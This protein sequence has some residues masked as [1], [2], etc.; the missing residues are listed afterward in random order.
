MRQTILKAGTMMLCLISAM[1]ISSC[2]GGSKTSQAEEAEAQPQQQ[3][4]QTLPDNMAKYTSNGFE[5]YWIC[6]NAGESKSDVSRYVGV[7]PEIIKELNISEGVPST[8]STFLIKADGK[9]LLFDAGMGSDKNLLLPSLKALGV[10][11]ENIDAIFI[12]HL[13]GD[14]T[15]GLAKDGKAVFPNATVYLSKQEYEGMDGAKVLE[16]YNGKI[17]QFDFN[18]ELI[19]GIKAIDGTGHTPGQACYLKGDVLIAGDIMHAVALQIVHPECCASFDKDIEASIATRIR[20]TNLAKEKKLLLCGA[21][22]PKGGVVD[23]RK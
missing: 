15:G 4:E 10:S 2:K 3:Q 14:H 7:T 22:F 8:M 11:P 12:T 20:I 16:P 9:N 13:H 23:F 17:V 6:D 21:H 19:A 5:T 1:F 18:D